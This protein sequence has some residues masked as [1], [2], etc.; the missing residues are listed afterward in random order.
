MMAWVFLVLAGFGEIGFVIFTKM[1]EGFKRH[2]FTALSMAAGFFSLFFL[3][4]AL[5]TISIG[6]GYAIWTGIGAAGSVILGMLFFGESR[7][8][9]RILFIAM[10]IF[11]VIGLKLI[12]SE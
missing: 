12:A 9:K 11:S 8:K 6:T 3:S 4:R 2:Q 1:S 7:N 10:I 5:M